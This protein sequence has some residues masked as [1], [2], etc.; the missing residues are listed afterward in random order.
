MASTPLIIGPDGVAREL[1]IFSTTMTSRFFEGTM[2]ADT[3]DMQISI[4]GGAFT[5]DP[6]LIIFEGTTFSFPNPQT[7]PDGL[8]LAAGRNIIEVRAVSFSGA[9]S[10]TAR[11][12][13][14][15]V[16]ESNIGLLGTV[17][18]NVSIEQFEDEVEIRVEGV[19]DSTFRGINFYASRFQGGGATGYQRI[20]LNTLSDVTVVQE[21]TPIG[22]VVADN[23]VAT[24][25]DGTPAADPLYV[26]IRETQT[27]SNDIIENLEDITLTPELAAAITEQEQ[28][29]LLRTDFVRTF[30]VPETVTTIRSNYTLEALVQRAFYT[31]RHD[32]QNGPASVPA[33]VPIGEFAATPLTE[34]LFYV[35]TAV[36]F[37]STTQLEV[38]SAFSAE[39][40]GTPTVIRDAVGTFPAPSRL[41]IVEDTLNAISRTTPQIA[42][43]PGAVIRDTVVDPAANEAVRLRFLVDFLYRVQS[44]DT[45]L[46]I[47]GI[48]ADGSSTPVAQSPYKQALQQVFELQNPADTQAIIDISFDQLASRNGVFRASGTRA[49]GFALFFTRSRP[50]ATIFIPLGTRIASGAVQFVTTTDGSIPINNVAAFFDPTTNTYRIELPIEAESTGTAANLGAGQIRTIVSSLPG[51]SVTNPNPTFGGTNQ[52]TNLQLSIRARNALAAVDTGTER[53]TLQVAADVAGV[54]EVSVVAAGDDLMQRDYDND[55]DKHVG[56]KVDVWLRGESVGTVTDTFAFTFETAR[57]VQFA[58]IGNPLALLFRALD[59]TLSPE[60]PLAEMLDDVQEGIGFRNA[61]TGAFFDLTDVQIVD[62]RTIQL[63]SDVFQP[64]AAFGDILLGDYRYTTTTRFVFTRQPVDTVASVTGTV[65]GELSTANWNFVRPD[66]PLILG[67]STEAQAYLDIVQVNGVPSGELIDVTDESHILLG[68]FNDFVNNL[69]ADPL[70]IEVTSE[71]GTILYRGPSDPSG[72]SD[73]TIVPGTQTTALAI[74]R[75][76]NSSILS[77]QTVF[78]DYSHAENFTV[79]YQTNFVIPTAQ[80]TLDAQ[81][82]LT[83]DVLAKAAVAIPVDITATVVTQSG[84]R[85][86]TAD[87]NVRTNLTTFLRALPVGSAVRQSDIIAVIDNTSG[88][89]YVESPLRKLTRSAGSLTVRESVPSEDG[90][91]MVLV[92]TTDIPY[93]TDTVKTWLLTNPL[94]NP[95]V[96]GG[97]DGTQF[98]GVFQDDMTLMLETTDP[99]ILKENPGQAFIIGNTGLVIPGFSDDQTITTN[100]PAA[101]TAQEIQEIREQLTANRIM[102]SLAANDRPQLHAYTATYTVAFVETRVQDLEAGA[103]EYFEV[104]NLIFTFVEDTRSV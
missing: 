39:V 33:T 30:E 88:V 80:A 74:R 60:N 15:L 87:T 90:D 86:S 32:R 104:G 96:R 11:V 45:L 29:N 12:E 83:A 93:S 37:D 8:E 5:S 101:N 61:S 100:F 57:D 21:T 36:F 81:K 75:T 95:T 58:I 24:N 56:G 70:S 49:R 103:V 1:T 42:V 76:P 102:V 19:D 91:V 73:Y 77:G 26:K 18:T 63:S 78:V 97:G 66:D 92:G 64:I 47:D 25:P 79:E 7:F 53:G 54:Q 2:D 99:L 28:A 3:V 59:D 9:V 89:S 67:R 16:Q 85:T 38:E 43:Q 6:D 27:S 62:Y 51:L 35:A 94:D 23:P 98:T 34:P 20:N 65:S 10:A 17:P 13:V 14:T 68:E 22:T 50:T 69:G 48:E 40:S 41:D 46:Q 4:R 44:F 71:D 82:H 55:F 52:E 31:F 84:F 72:V